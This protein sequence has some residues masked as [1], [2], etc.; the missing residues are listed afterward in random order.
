MERGINTFGVISEIN[1]EL[2]KI[3]QLKQEQVS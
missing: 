3:I 1:E 2:L